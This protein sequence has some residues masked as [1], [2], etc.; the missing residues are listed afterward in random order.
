MRYKSNYLSLVIF[1][2]DFAPIPE[3]QLTT[4]PALSERIGD[5]FP[6]LTAIPS[7]QLSVSFNPGGSEVNQQAAS[8]TYQHRK[9]DADFPVVTLASNFLS[10]EYGKDAYGSFAPFKNEVVSIVALLQGLYASL[11]IKRLG[12]RYINEITAG[13]GN[14]LE[15]NGLINPDLITSIKAAIP[16]K[17]RLSRSMHQVQAFD[18]DLGVLLHYGIFNPDYPGEIARRQFLID[19]DSFKTGEIQVGEIVANLTTLNER[20][21]QIFEESIDGGLREKMGEFHE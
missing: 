16:K 2:I 20:C 17:M 8:I 10:I 1:R 11:S 19:I 7:L 9:A 13:H 15:W 6:K 4:R 18:D 21:E 12:L 3:L 14:G 5:L